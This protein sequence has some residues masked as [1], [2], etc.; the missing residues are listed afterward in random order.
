MEKSIQKASATE[1]A[2]T[3]ERAIDSFVTRGDWSGLSPT[4]RARLYV[5]VCEEYGLN[6]ASQPFAFL[7]LNGKEVLYATRGATDQLAAIHKLNREIIDGPKVIDLA[8]TKLVCAVCR[9]THPNGRIET[10]IATVP[11][12]DPVNVLMKAE[13][14]AKRRA[15]LSILGLGTL[16][17]IELETIPASAQQPAVQVS[18][19]DIEQARTTPKQEVGSFEPP[20]SNEEGPPPGSAA[21]GEG[22]PP[23]EQEGPSSRAFA[24]YHSVVGNLTTLV[25][26]R[27][28]YR[29]LVQDLYEEGLDPEPFTSGDEGAWALLAARTATLGHRLSKAEVSQVIA[30]DGLAEILDSQVAIKPCADAL[31]MAADWWVRHRDAVKKLDPAH[32]T[33]PW[34]ALV[35]RYSDARDGTA[36]KKANQMLEAAVKARDSKNPPPSGPGGGAPRPTQGTTINVVGGSSPGPSSEDLPPAALDEFRAHLAEIP[37]RGQDRGAARCAGAYWKRRQGVIDE[38]THAEALADV[39]DA[40]SARGIAEPSPYLAEIGEKNGYVQ[41]RTTAQVAA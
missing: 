34:Y 10:S 12:V 41:R 1:M 15:T 33:A 39:I 2:R 19:A 4:D 21:E 16:D 17:E 40:L 24:H 26:L 6:P 36:T 37:E 29:G 18:R 38:G 20:P 30:S 8:G 32:R 13:T 23:P 22:E 35:R 31:K 11:L 9:A 5:S 14:K 3:M 27:D 7:R 28:A 25:A